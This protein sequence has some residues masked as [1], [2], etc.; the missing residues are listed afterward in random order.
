[1]HNMTY[2]AK[3]VQ[4]L[5]EEALSSVTADAWVK[6]CSHVEKIEKEFWRSD[7]A[8]ERVIDEFIIHVSDEEATDTASESSNY[9]DTDSAIEEY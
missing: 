5:T 2:S 9:S 7:V 8:V 3:S 4:Q 6:C 1:M